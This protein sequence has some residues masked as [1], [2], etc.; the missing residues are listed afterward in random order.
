MDKNILKYTTMP[1]IVPTMENHPSSNTEQKEASWP[2]QVAWVGRWLSL[3]IDLPEHMLWQT[4]KV[5]DNV[6]T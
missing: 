2:G 4:L 3:F 1:R 5:M 6:E